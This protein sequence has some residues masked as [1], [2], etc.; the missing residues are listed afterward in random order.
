ML[1]DCKWNGDK[2]QVK[3]GLG[4]PKRGGLILNWVIWEDLHEGDTQETLE[5][6]EGL[7]HT[8]FW[9][10][11]ITDL[12]STYQQRSWGDSCLVF[13]EEQEGQRCLSQRELQQ[14]RKSNKELGLVCGC[15]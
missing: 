10:E 8:C 12:G 15:K 3:G 6:S 7:S 2:E 4:V 9:E 13:W 11:N 1:K 5:P 14:Y